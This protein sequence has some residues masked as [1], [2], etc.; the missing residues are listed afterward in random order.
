[1]H[2]QH[3]KFVRVNLLCLVTPKAKMIYNQLYLQHHEAGHFSLLKLE[4][5]LSKM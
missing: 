3:L 2:C 1:M 4:G 5:L